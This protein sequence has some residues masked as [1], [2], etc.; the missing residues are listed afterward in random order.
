MVYDTKRPQPRPDKVAV[1]AV[2]NAPQ[3]IST[4]L[5][6]RIFLPVFTDSREEDLSRIFLVEFGFHSGQSK[7]LR[8]AAPF[9]IRFLQLVRGRRPSC[10][11]IISPFHKGRATGC[12]NLCS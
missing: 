3:P 6:S 2:P 10:W 4:A 8:F 5:A 12:A 1:I 11:L 9:A 7:H